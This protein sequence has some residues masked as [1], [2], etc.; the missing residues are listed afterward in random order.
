[1]NSTQRSKRIEKKEAMPL[2]PPKLNLNQL[3]NEE[4]LKIENSDRHS[5]ASSKRSQN[6]VIKLNNIEDLEKLKKFQ[7][8][9]VDINI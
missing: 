2:A 3:H 4:R 6:V 5:L 1:M 8:D 7:E 9:N